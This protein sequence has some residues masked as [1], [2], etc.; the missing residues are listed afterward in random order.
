MPTRRPI[1]DGYLDEVFT[2]A[3]AEEATVEADVLR[4]PRK[5]ARPHPRG[6]AKGRRERKPTHAARGTEDKWGEVSV[7][8]DRRQVEFVDS[9]VETL[10]AA[11][12]RKANPQQVARVLVDAVL[13]SR[14]DFSHIDSLEAMQ[15]VVRASFRPP[16]LLDLPQS[17][18]DASL[19]ALNPWTNGLIDLVRNRN[20]SSRR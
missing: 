18:L 15:R 19:R 6:K 8:L 20:R 17:I 10:R 1:A 5:A 14:I 12:V 2:P 9:I 3:P 7:P 11:G 13:E 4:A 16:S